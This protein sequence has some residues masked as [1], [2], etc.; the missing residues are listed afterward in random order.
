M[1]DDSVYLLHIADAIRRIEEFTSGLDGKGFMASR[2]VQSAVIRE[3]EVIG[4]ASKQVSEKFKK[5]APGIPWKR[6]SGMRDK[7]IHGYFGVDL[8]AVWETISK[9]LP[10]LKR[11]LGEL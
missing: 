10:E 9:D 11:R 4:E 7:L 2:L 6:I 8:D 5:S 3:F 1:K